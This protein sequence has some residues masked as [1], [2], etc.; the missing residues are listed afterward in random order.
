MPLTVFFFPLRAASE[1]PTLP[2][3]AF[4]H[5]KLLSSR[6]YR[7][8]GYSPLLHTSA[9]QTAWRDDYVTIFLSSR[10]SISA[11]LTEA[12]IETMITDGFG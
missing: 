2:C 3:V 7:T 10:N 6:Y 5:K 9:N 11:E 1:P 12:V 4:Y 8:K